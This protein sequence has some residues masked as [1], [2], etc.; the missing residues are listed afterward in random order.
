M[1]SS[2]SAAWSPSGIGMLLI[3]APHRV[4]DREV[5]AAG[6]RHAPPAVR[7]WEAR[8]RGRNRGMIWLLLLLLLILVVGVIG[9]VK[10]ALWVILIALVVALLA[11]FLGRG[12]FSR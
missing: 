3:D 2:R 5:P 12:L 1:R 4:G 10:I 7:D 6:N 8:L 9:A 11:G